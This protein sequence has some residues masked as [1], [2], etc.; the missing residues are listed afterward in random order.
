MV[1]ERRSGRVRWPMPTML[2]YYLVMHVTMTPI[3]RSETFQQFS[4]WFG[5]VGRADR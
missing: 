2:G 3:A 5:M 4:N 1:L